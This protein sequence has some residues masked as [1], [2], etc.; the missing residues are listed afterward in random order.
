[1]AS[2][3]VSTASGRAWAWAP[4]ATSAWARRNH[5]IIRSGC[6]VAA[7]SGERADE[8]FFG[9]LVVVDEDAEV[10]AGKI[11]PEIEF[12]IEG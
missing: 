2:R 12:Q 10:L 9:A 5:A 3:K 8:S 4:K 11:E 7:G 6:S 1:M